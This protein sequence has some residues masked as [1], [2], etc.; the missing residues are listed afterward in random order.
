MADA[1]SLATPAKA[2]ALVHTSGGFTSPNTLSEPKDDVN[3][4]SENQEITLL[5]RW[6]GVSPFAG[7]W[8][9]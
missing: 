9:I 3:F 1:A 4:F 2:K 5:H 6:N 7:E 8:P